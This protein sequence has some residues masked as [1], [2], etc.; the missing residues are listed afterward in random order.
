ML[1]LIGEAFSSLVTYT[2][3]QKYREEINKTEQSKKLTK[4]T[5]LS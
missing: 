5:V 3:I 1:Q 4:L 2:C